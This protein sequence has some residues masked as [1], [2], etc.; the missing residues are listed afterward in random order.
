MFR[1]TRVRATTGAREHAGVHDEQVAPTVTAAEGIHDRL[2]RVMAHAAGPEDVG[3]VE[4]VVRAVLLEY[5]F[6]A[7][8]PQ[9]LARLVRHKGQTANLQLYC[10][11]NRSP[12]PA[13]ERGAGGPSWPDPRR[14]NASR[15]HG[16]RGVVSSVAPT[17][18]GRRC[19]RPPGG[20]RHRLPPAPPRRSCRRRGSSRSRRLCAT[21]IAPSD[22]AS[23]RPPPD[24][25]SAPSRSVQSR[26]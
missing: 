2:L 8:G 24:S 10:R 9:D 22:A 12:S 21:A 3:G 7:R 14:R 19:S 5:V 26:R 23:D 17:S 6:R 16:F 4:E 20:R 13:P 11:S 25:R 1:E 15:A 18:G